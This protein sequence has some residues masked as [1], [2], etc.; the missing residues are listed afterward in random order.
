MST[1]SSC[2]AATGIAR[3][4]VALKTG[5]GDADR[6]GRR[7]QRRD[8]ELPLPVGGDRSR[9]ARPIVGHHDRGTRHKGG[10][11]VAHRPGN[12]SLLALG[13]RGG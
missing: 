12:A 4:S 3:Y 9:L 11:L 5:H 7:F 8:E 6:V 13:D 10:A 1:V 2:P